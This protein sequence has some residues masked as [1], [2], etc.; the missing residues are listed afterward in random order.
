MDNTWTIALLA[1]ELLKI[2]PTMGRLIALRLRES[3]EEETTFMH[4]G[5]LHQLQE[6]CLTAS[7]LAKKRRVSLQS[8]SVL[9]QSMVER[10]WIVREPSPKDRRQFLLQVTPEGLERA[11]AAKKQIAQYMEQF[12]DGLSAEEIEAGHRF[13]PALSRILTNQMAAD[14]L[15]T[16]RQATAE[17]EKTPL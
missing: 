12:L 15:K 16:E 13:L 14:N 4:I 3:G 2:F 5:V 11:E 6:H 9:I 1:E 8:A 10:G 7:E 17:E